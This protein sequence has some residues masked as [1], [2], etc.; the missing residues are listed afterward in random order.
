MATLNI[1]SIEPPPFNLRKEDLSKGWAL[2]E[3]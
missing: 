3:N 1:S 2:V